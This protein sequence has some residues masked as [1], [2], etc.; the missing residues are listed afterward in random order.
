MFRGKYILTHVPEHAAAAAAAE[1][2]DARR[3]QQGRGDRS[4][5][6]CGEQLEAAPAATRPARRAIASS[7]RWALRSRTSTRSGSGATTGADGAPI[8]AAGVLADGAKVDGPVALRERHPEPARR[9]RHHAHRADADLRAGPRARAV[10]HARR[11][12]H[13][14]EG[15]AERLPLHV[16]HHRDRR[17]RAVP[18]AG[19]AGTG[20]NRQPRRTSEGTVSHDHHEEASVPPHVPARHLRR[21]GGAAVARRDGAGAHGAVAHGCARAVPLRRVYMPNGVFPDTWH[22]DAG[23]QRLRS[24]SR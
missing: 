10:R 8:D 19:Q 7:T 9:V 2:P 6:R 5:R 18:D 17:E 24:S 15:G 21:R 11:A 13:R 4:R 20:G 22:P 16:D 3:E 12:A 14:E 23:R 1:R